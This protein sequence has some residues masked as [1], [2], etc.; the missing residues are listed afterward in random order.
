MSEGNEGCWFTI[1]PSYKLRALGDEVLIGD[2]VIFVNT[3]TQLPLHVSSCQLEDHVDSFEVNVA[4]TLKVSESLKTSWKLSLFLE[5]HKTPEKILK[6]GDVI[7]FFHAE[8]EKFLT[9]DLYENELRVF[10]RS[11]ARATKTDAT[12]S[13]A[14]WEVEVVGGKI[15]NT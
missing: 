14:L 8:Q 2:E 9:C 5:H 15:M 4:E 10:L 7:R 6:G 3:V 1:T 13:Q 12:S 11:T